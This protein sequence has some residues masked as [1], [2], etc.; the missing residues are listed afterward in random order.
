MR[1]IAYV[2]APEWATSAPDYALIEISD[3]EAL[4]TRTDLIS[5]LAKKL[6]YE[7]GSKAVGEMFS[8]LLWMNSL[9]NFITV[10]WLHRGALLP[11]DYDGVDPEW[12]E[13]LDQYNLVVPPADWEPRLEDAEGGSNVFFECDLTKLEIYPDGT[14]DVQANLWG[15]PDRVE[16]Q[17]FSLKDFEV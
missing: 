16:T 2:H 15:G 4:K 13:D 14:M 8:T 9:Y 12:V 11:V 3:V 10:T 17:E 7:G 6:G 5:K 1:L